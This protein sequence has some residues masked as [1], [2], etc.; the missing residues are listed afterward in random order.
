MSKIA[1]HVVGTSRDNGGFGISGIPGSWKYGADQET[2][3]EH[4]NEKVHGEPAHA[5]QG[6]R[7]A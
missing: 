5:I 2:L 3:H 6:E 1:L 4:S 7:I